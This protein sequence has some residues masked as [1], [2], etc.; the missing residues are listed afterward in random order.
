MYAVGRCLIWPTGRKGNPSHDTFSA[1]KPRRAV[2][3][4]YHLFILHEVESAA[5]DNSVIQI[6]TVNGQVN[7]QVNGRL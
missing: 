1:A 3:F 5:N 4:M 6:V 2:L 7:G